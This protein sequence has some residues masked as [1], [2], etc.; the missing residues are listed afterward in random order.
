MHAYSQ[1]D[2]SS[3]MPAQ[4]PSHDLVHFDRPIEG[5]KLTSILRLFLCATAA[6]QR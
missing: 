6:C 5:N 1:N 3:I 4:R 2:Q